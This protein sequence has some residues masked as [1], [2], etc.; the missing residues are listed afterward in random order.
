MFLF[1][2]TQRGREGE[3]EVEKHQCVVASHRSL[4]R[5]LAS[6]PGKCP[7]WVRTS[8]CLV[9][10]LAL[11]PLSHTRPELA[12]FL[13][14][15]RFYLFLERRGR[16]KEREKQQCVVASSA[17]PARDLAYNPGMCPNWESNWRPVSSQASA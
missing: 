6:N 16:E 15:L 9:H 5:D 3:R 4:T 13:S 7:D 11:N 8:N 10:R 2:S 1:I 12:F 14:F 17:P